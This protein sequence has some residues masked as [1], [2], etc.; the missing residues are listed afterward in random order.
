M[1]SFLTYA[2]ISHL[3]WSFIRCEDTYGL[4][5]SFLTYALISHLGLELG[6]QCP[7]AKAVEYYPYPNKPEIALPAL[8]A[9]PDNQ[10][11]TVLVVDVTV[12][13]TADV[14]LPS[15]EAASL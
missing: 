4:H 8:E 9:A 3:R 2:L 6:I 12:L 7:I 5:D 15:A 11:V 14:V 10:F 13:L 1:Y